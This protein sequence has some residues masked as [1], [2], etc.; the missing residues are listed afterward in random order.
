M[1]QIIMVLTT[2]VTATIMSTQD[3]TTTL[4]MIMITSTKDSSK[5]YAT[6]IIIKNTFE[7]NKP[8]SNQFDVCD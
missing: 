2:Q 4:Q 7:K 6:T 3:N 8:D 1:I 5:I